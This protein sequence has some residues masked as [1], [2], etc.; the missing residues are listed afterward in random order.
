ML[1]Q[2]YNPRNFIKSLAAK[3]NIHPIII[4]FNLGLNTN[5]E[6]LYREPEIPINKYLSTL[7]G[8]H[9]QDYV[10]RYYTLSTKEN[11][12]RIKKIAV[13]QTTLSC[14]VTKGTKKEEWCSSGILNLM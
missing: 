8:E 6:S 1:E 14:T 7:S 2:Y 12:S 3:Y 4:K 13:L 9:R 10:Q 11:H 5:A